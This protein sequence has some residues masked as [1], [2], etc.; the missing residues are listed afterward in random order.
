MGGIALAEENACESGPFYSSEFF[1]VSA[2][3]Y[4]F[5]YALGF[6][7]WNLVVIAGLIGQVLRHMLPRLRSPLRDRRKGL[8][9]AQVPTCGRPTNL[10]RHL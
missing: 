9:V 8:R 4:A 2:L 5:G 1:G 10:A 7:S 6:A 3:G